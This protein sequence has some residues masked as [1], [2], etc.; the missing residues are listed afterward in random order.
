MFRAFSIAQKTK[1]TFQLC[2]ENRN[3]VYY[4]QEKFRIKYIIQHIYISYFISFV[5][6]TRIYI[7]NLYMH[8]INT[9]SMAIPM[10]SLCTIRRTAVREAGACRNHVCQITLISRQNYA[11]GFKGK[12]GA[13]GLN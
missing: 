11:E 1:I 8:I 13:G 9:R 4:I 6:L 5:T 10:Y 3:H 7:H 2:S 12:E